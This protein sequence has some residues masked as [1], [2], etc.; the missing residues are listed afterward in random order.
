MTDRLCQHHLINATIEPPLDN[1][2]K[3]RRTEVRVA[4]SVQYQEENLLALG[5]ADR[6]LLLT[7]SQPSAR[8]FALLAQ[9]ESGKSAN[10]GCPGEPN[11]DSLR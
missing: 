4:Q 11:N 2:R 7:T 5:H 10:I 8:P 1:P 6:Q 3:R 9:L